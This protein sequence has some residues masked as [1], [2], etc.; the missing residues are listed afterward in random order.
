ME[1]ELSPIPLA[2]TLSYR[3]IKYIGYA[4]IKYYKF[5]TGKAAAILLSYTCFHK[6]SLKYLFPENIPSKICCKKMPGV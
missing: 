6:I 1:V 2:Y 4:E 5:P 3:K